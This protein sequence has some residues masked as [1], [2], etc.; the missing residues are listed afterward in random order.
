MRLCL[1]GSYSCVPGGKVGVFRGQ[2]VSMSI[3]GDAMA[4]STLRPMGFARGR[5]IPPF[6]FGLGKYRSL[7]VGSNSCSAQCAG[8]SVQARVFTY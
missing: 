8:L 4:S 5:V 2:T 1:F 3:T 6:P 7:V